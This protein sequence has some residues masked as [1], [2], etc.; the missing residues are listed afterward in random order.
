MNISLKSLIVPGVI[1]LL[2]LA[3]W[4]LYAS[5]KG[6][7]KRADDAEESANSAVTITDNVLRTIKIT[8]IVLE[9]NQHAKEQ[10]ALESQ[11]TKTDIKVAVANDDCARRPVPDAAADRLRK[12]ADSLREG[13]GSTSPGKPHS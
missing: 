7:K 8:N 12:Y 5:Y 13:S 2:I 6:E 4:L 9:S 10:I 3:S 11:R 1:L